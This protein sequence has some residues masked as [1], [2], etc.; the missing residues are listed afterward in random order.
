MNK[1][2]DSL[3]PRE[4]L[5]NESPLRGTLRNHYSKK[6][7]N[8]KNHKKCLELSQISFE[9]ASFGTTE[10]IAI[11]YILSKCAEKELNIIK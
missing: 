11:S 3:N 1:K 2:D 10:A 4:S 9:V 5:K 6:E 7:V 8:I